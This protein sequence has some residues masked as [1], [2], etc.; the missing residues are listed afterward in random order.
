MRVAI[1][2]QA[3]IVPA[4]SSDRMSVQPDQMLAKIQPPIG[5]MWLSI[6]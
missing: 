1:D 4:E 5:T 6:V 2:L 3:L